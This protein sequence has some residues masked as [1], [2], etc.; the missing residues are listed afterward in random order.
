M[1]LKSKEKAKGL[2][3]YFA[4]LASI[5]IPVVG[6]SVLASGCVQEA[7]LP[8]KSAAQVFEPNPGVLSDADG[9]S[10]SVESL[11]GKVV[12]LGSNALVNASGSSCSFGD[13][14][15]VHTIDLSEC[16]A[17]QAV[18]ISFIGSNNSPVSLTGTYD[19]SG[20][21]T[22]DGDN[23]GVTNAN[24]NCPVDPN[25]NQNDNDDD[26][27]G[28]VCDADDDND[29][30]NDDVDNCPITANSDQDPAACSGV[31]D[32]DN[33]TIPDSIDNCETVWN[34]DQSND[35]GDELGNVCDPTPVVVQLP[36]ANDDLVQ[37]MVRWKAQVQCDIRC[38]DPT[39]GGDVGTLNC[40]GGGTAHWTVDLDILGGE[41]NSVFTFTNC[42]YTTSEGDNLIINGQLI[43]FSDFDGNGNEEGTVSVV[44]GGEYAGEL[45]SHAIFANKATSGGY[46]TAGCTEDPLVNEECKAAGAAVDVFY[47]NWTC[48]NGECDG[49]APLVDTD[50]DGVFDRYD[51]CPAD[52]NSDQANSDFDNQG[53]DV[54]DA[55]DTSD[56]DND[57]IPDS[58]D[59]CPSLANPG[60][61]DIDGDS[62]G[63]VCDATPEGDND[64]VSFASDNCVFVDNEDQANVFGDAA[65]SVAGYEGDVCED[66]DGDGVV[67]ADDTCPNDAQDNCQMG[68][69][70]TIYNKSRGQCM[71]NDN[72]NI[73]LA[74]CDASDVNQQWSLVRPTA[75][76]TSKWM[77]QQATDQSK[78]VSN[79]GG[80]AKIGACANEDKF[81]MGMSGSDENVEIKVN[82]SGCLY[83]INS[84][85]VT[86]WGNCLLLTE[87]RWGFKLEGAGGWVDAGNLQSK[88]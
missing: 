38:S 41:A 76:N 86:V 14:L 36:L 11:G 4:P 56:L 81:K 87:I 43:Q 58:G 79:E 29:G 67:D 61:E 45:T 1:R 75:T 40:S 52:A 26:S 17:D 7:V 73:R 5:V 44:S 19:T 74:A 88:N 6:L 33:D 34:K 15:A 47:P 82:G 84:N 31:A 9:L 71:Y 42:N 53:G 64:T 21:S 35:D 55:P 22:C 83:S 3:Q 80:D 65:D 49:G 54:C 70:Y 32:S 39:G 78:C 25:A 69:W 66:Q 57:G 8:E 72:G 50:G 23:D 20:Y 13:E 77:I 18:K 68:N 60:Q 24:D 16:L 63:D 85:N 12:C 46:W 37:A 10:V 62:E 48:Q 28:D 59:N 27:M 30:V 2:K 51:N